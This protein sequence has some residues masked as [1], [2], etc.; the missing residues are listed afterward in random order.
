MC[1]QYKVSWQATGIQDKKQKLNI[2]D[3]VD[4]CFSSSKGTWAFFVIRPVRKQVCAAVIEWT[5]QMD[6]ERLD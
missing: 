2:Q 4:A 5:A 1:L 3:P 6:R